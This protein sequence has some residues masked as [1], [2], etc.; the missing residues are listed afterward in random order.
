METKVFYEISREHKKG[1][2]FLYKELKKRGIAG[3]KPGLTRNFKL[4]TYGFKK[5][6]L[7]RIIDAFKEISMLK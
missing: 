3:I 1:R 7:K 4:S 5:D 2:F 6:E